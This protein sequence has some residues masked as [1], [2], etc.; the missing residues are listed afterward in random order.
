MITSLTPEQEAQI[1]IYREKWKQ[2]ALSTQSIERQKAAAAIVSGYSVAGIKIPK[3]VFCDSPY[4]AFVYT[5]QEESSWGKPTK[6]L[7][8]EVLGRLGSQIRGQLDNQL[9]SQITEEL[10][11]E[12]QRL[13]KPE[14]THLV[15][16]LP[17]MRFGLWSALAEQLQVR[18][19]QFVID[20]PPII[21]PMQ[22][23]W[24]GSWF[25][26]CISELNCTYDTAKWEVFEA[27]VQVCGWILPY[28]KVC[29]V[30]ERPTYISFDGNCPVYA[31]G[32]AT[33]QY[34]DG[35]SITGNFDGMATTKEFQFVFPEAA[36][37]S[38]LSPNE[39]HVRVG[40]LAPLITDLT[41]AQETQIPI[42]REK[43]KAIVFK[44]GQIDQQQARAAISAA[45]TAIGET[46]PEIVFFSN[47]Q[48]ALADKNENWSQEKFGLPLDRRFDRLLWADLENE[49]ESQLGYELVKRLT[50]EFNE[51]LNSLYFGSGESEL[52]R[53]LGTESDT[54]DLGFYINPRWWSCAGA[55]LDFCI[56]VLNCTHNP[57]RW[58]AFQAIVQHCGWMFPY[59]KV[60]YVCERPIKVFIPADD[61]DCF[62]S[63]SEPI[64]QFADGFNL[65]AL[66]QSL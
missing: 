38:T 32:E 29:L 27:L 53:R 11:R 36:N 13:N 56:S 20:G 22:W 39:M 26:F 58:Q 8:E 2:I 60:C 33:L 62:Q 61:E 3:I 48:V 43:W 1:A 35:F 31:V 12:L 14:E 42:Y 18:W 6:L 34:A 65:Y 23:S 15:F 9:S 63:S 66:K 46:P 21:D 19:W 51:K 28:E 52:S 57:E 49:L 47:P 45:Y 37:W 16:N 4:A 41:L 64:I 40:L 50:C 17:I 54:I 25:D 24:F 59:T 55:F 5:S 7:G 44:A 10:K 30:C